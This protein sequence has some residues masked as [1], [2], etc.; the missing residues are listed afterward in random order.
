[1]LRPTDLPF[2]KRVY[3]PRPLSNEKEVTMH[4]LKNKLKRTT[5]EYVQKIK[6]DARNK[7]PWS[8]LT[9]EELKGLK[10]LKERIKGENIVIYQTDK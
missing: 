9:P 5:D 6:R 10:T 2:N 7:T 8:N 3:L 1:M 4:H